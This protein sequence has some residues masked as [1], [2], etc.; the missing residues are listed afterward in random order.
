MR[1]EE[2][3][4]TM[5]PTWHS[6]LVSILDNCVYKTPI[7]ISLTSY[8]FYWIITLVWIKVLGF[9]SIQTNGGLEGGM[10]GV[11]TPSCG[12]RCCFNNRARGRWQ[13]VADPKIGGRSHRKKNGGRRSEGLLLPPATLFH[14]LNQMAADPL[15][16]WLMERRARAKSDAPYGLQ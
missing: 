7:E 16:P 12:W 6:Y 13:E 15:A 11:A 2:N 8:V 4:I 9:L 1:C 3:F 5:K 10:M 14:Q